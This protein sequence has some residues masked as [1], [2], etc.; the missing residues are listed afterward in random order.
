MNKVVVITGGSSGIGR[1]TAS[2]FCKNGY[3]VYELSRREI[4]LDGVTHI[5]ADVTDATSI[6][7]AIDSIIS[8]EGKI[9]VLVANAGMG[10]SGAVESTTPTEVKKI[11]SVNVF[12]V[13]NT[14]NAVIPY[15]RKN[16]GGKIICTS[17][18]A[19]VVSIPFQTFY[20]MTKSSVNSLVLGLRNE[21]K[22]FN[23]KVAAVMPGDVKTGFTDAREKSITNLS[24]YNGRVERSVQQ[25]EKDEQSGMPPILIAK[26]IY[27]LANKKSPKPL[28]TVG[29][30][31]KLICML[32]K[33]LPSSLS[34]KIV[35]IIYAK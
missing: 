8:K 3:K 35:G 14:I 17:S 23:I 26:K 25:M 11:F 13:V 15:M 7:A 6:C 33:L 1:E 22:P 31:Y 34:N 28:S 24:E 9:D 32:I 2:Y 21:L 20:S 30:G 4:V 29:I 19:G 18:V 5:T 27:S 12:G 16:G 10:I